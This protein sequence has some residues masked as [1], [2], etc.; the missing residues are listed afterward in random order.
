[1]GVPLITPLLKINPAGNEGATLS[2]LGARPPVLVATGDRLVI[3]L[4]L[5]KLT[6]GLLIANVS[7]GSS[8]INVIVTVSV[9]ETVN[10]SVAVM[11]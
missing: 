10:V 2:V 11:T 8:V 9:C 1:M 6:A 3:A 4:F 7:A 5:V